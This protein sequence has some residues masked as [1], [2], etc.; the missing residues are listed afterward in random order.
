M[1]VCVLIG[2]FAIYQVFFPL[3]QGN[4]VSLTLLWYR[5]GLRLRRTKPVSDEQREHEVP[6]GNPTVVDWLLAA[7]ALV[8]CLYPV[9][10]IEIAGGGGGFDKFLSRQGTPAMIDVL[11][12]TV[13]LLLVLEACRR[14]TPPTALASV[15]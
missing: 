1:A 6:K 13:V 10:P 4:Q 9:L 5:S 2:V 8:A 7:I 3:A 11:V 14:T 15:E 12:G